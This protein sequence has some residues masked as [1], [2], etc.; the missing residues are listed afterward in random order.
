MF[1]LDIIRKIIYNIGVKDKE[2]VERLE[3][4]ENIKGKKRKNKN[5]EYNFNKIDNLFKNC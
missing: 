4:S 1:L 2:K 5:D 3:K